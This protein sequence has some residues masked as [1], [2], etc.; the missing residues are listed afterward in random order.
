MT[1]VTDNGGRIEH[2]LPPENPETALCG[3]IIDRPREAAA[4]GAYRCDDCAHTLR[5]ERER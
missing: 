5:L 1:W 3:K 2:W 4:R